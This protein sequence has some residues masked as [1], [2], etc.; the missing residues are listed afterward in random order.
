M[1]TAELI[2]LLQK[3]DPEGTRQFVAEDENG[4]DHPV[5]GVWTNEN[6]AIGISIDFDFE[7]EPSGHPC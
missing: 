4:D 3:I 2:T 1:T 5:T 6:G 7:D